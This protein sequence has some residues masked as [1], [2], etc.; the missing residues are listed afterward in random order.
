ME[1]ATFFDRLRQ[2]RLL[3][4]AELE[5]AS[6]RFGDADPTQGIADALV[7]EGVLT[8]FQARQVCAG[9][10]QPLTLG[11]YRLLDELGRGG[12]GRVYK[13]LHTIMGRVVAIKVISPELVR[14]PV[15]VEWFHREVRASTH[16]LH[17]NIVMAYDAN[18]A[19]GLH[20]LVMEYVHGVTLDTLV[21]QRGLLPVD[22]VCAL[23]RQ[24]ALG[25]QHAHEKGMVHR[26]IKPANLLIPRVE[27]EQ[28]PDILVKIVDF[29]LARLQGKTHGDTIAL[30]GEVGVLGTPDYIS[31]EQ[32]RDIHAADIRS[33]L[34]SL[35]CAFYYALAGR[36]PFPGEHAM[37]KL[38][39][40]MME[41]PEPLKKMRP[42]VPPEVAAFVA[43]LM[44]K[45]PA[46]RYQTPA[47]LVQE[48]D[49]WTLERPKG[50]PATQTA[51][52][53]LWLSPPTRMAIDPAAPSETASH[54]RLLDRVELF[55]A[56]RDDEPSNPSLLE[57]LWKHSPD[58]MRQ[59]QTHDTLTLSRAEDTEVTTDPA[60][61][62][63]TPERQRR[64]DSDSTQP[65]VATP[66]VAVPPADPAAAQQIETQLL[67]LW[68]RW[69]ELIE[70][71]VLGRGPS[72]V[73]GDLYRAVHAALLQVC[74]A[75]IESAPTPP[76]RAFYQ[77][78]VSIA[79]PWL[80]LKTFAHIEPQMLKSLLERCK[81]IELELNDGNIPWTFRELLLLVLVTVSPVALALWYWHSGRRWLS[82]LVRSSHWESSSTSLRSVWSFVESHP[83][84]LMDVLF[85]VV[86]IFSL[87]LLTRRPRS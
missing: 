87:Y 58:E 83:S 5:R 23:M 46:D 54:T 69:T 40:H 59:P 51:C 13:A 42:D 17:P 80:N 71:I 53:P 66:S 14:D 77:E 78:L 41:E 26:D 63:T 70:T 27:S 10:T 86:I 56:S 38:I 44:A 18:E 33:D 52:R 35:G 32:S 15:A 72:R 39:K 6:S 45:N 64:V 49:R 50:V 73:N 3:T 16:L 8:S 67:R 57:P 82:S 9:D 47:E 29:G 75:G 60:T 28:T 36:V 74:R 25:L 79:Q 43:K 65:E 61:A 81:Q 20:F 37:E 4:E 84:M 11:Q 55:G 62:L 30:R 34:Y 21:K 12:M 2:N 7:E 85:P 68:R 22:H 76:R 31:P 48:L 19:D 1:R 24:A